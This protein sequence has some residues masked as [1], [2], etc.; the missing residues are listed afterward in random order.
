MYVLRLCVCVFCINF[1]SLILPFSRS[2][3]FS[4]SL[5]HSFRI[6]DFLYISF[7]LILSLKPYHGYLR[8]LCNVTVSRVRVCACVCV[9]V[10]MHPRI[11]MYRCVCTYVSCLCVACRM[12]Y[13]CFVRCVHMGGSVVVGE[14]LQVVMYL[15]LART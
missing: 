13:L 2:L 9:Y 12:R 4:L 1:F 8:R 11:C 6:C 5:L 3:A 15:A 14:R 10:C 7:F